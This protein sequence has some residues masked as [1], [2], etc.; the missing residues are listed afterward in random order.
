MSK[1]VK[2]LI[3][4][5]VA[6]LLV[7]AATTATVMAQEEPE[8]TP[9]AG[10]KGLLARVAEILDIPQEELIDAFKQARQELRQEA[11]LRALDMAVE[12]ELITQDE[13]DQ[14]M[15]WWQQK[16]E[17]LDQMRLRRFCAPSDLGQ[18]YLWR[19]HHDGHGPGPHWPPVD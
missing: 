6:I 11:C 7:V 15:G 4:V 19:E 17:V 8:S 3:S 14:I 16:P 13:A 5:M 10:V 18:R 1:K 12:K 2:V 9:E